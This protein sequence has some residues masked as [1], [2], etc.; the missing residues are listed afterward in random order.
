M[1]AIRHM[2]GFWTLKI[3]NKCTTLVLLEYL[4]RIH[5]YLI[6]KWVLSK[7]CLQGALW[8][9]LP[10]APVGELSSAS[11]SVG[12]ASGSACFLH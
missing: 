2:S 10:A 4:F 7:Q 6:T 5:E 3:K 1:Q 8:K 11:I 9:A 12:F